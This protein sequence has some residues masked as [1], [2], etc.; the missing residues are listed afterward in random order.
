MGGANGGRV[1]IRV[2]D[3]DGANFHY[4]ERFFKT[5]DELFA[6]CLNDVNPT[7]VDRVELHGVDDEGTARTVLL[8]FQAVTGRD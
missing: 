6:L 4:E 3:A 8:K 7:V 1:V 5:L 2:Q